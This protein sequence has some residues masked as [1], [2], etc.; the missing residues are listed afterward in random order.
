MQAQIQSFVSQMQD[1]IT[2][3]S[4]V[5]EWAASLPPVQ[6]AQQAVI[7]TFQGGADATNGVPAFLG[8]SAGVIPYVSRGVQVADLLPIW[9]A[10]PFVNLPASAV[11]VPLDVAAFGFGL[12]D[13]WSSDCSTRAKIGMSFNTSA[14]LSF[15]LGGQALSVLA[16]P[17]LVGPAAISILVSA[18]EATLYTANELKLSKC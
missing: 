12:Y 17:S 14:N 7:N 1:F 13:V 4:A 2:Y 6:T 3:M 8:D 9:G 11:G 18:A 5:T 15:G 16:S 10:I